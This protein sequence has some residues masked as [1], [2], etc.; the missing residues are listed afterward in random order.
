[1]ASVSNHDPQIMQFC[2]SHGPYHCLDFG[3]IDGV[4]WLITQGTI[5]GWLLTSSK[6][7]DGT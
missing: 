5:L 6:V 2:P 3:G 7:Q 1:M 4:Y